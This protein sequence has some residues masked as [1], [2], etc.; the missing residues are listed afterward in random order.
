MRLLHGPDDWRIE[1]RGSEQACVTY[2]VVDG[3]QSKYEIER[4][5]AGDRMVR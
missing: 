1:G 4:V 5:P 3:N 2:A